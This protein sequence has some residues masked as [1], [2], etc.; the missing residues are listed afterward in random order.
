MKVEMWQAIVS[1]P[2]IT[3]LIGWVCRSIKRLPTDIKEM[4]IQ[5]ANWL[6]S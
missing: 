1:A 2:V 5:T 6:K 3:V 4:F